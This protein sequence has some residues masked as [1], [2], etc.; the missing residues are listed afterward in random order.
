MLNGGDIPDLIE[1]IDVNSIH[2]YAPAP[3][4]FLC[5]GNIDATATELTSLR[6]AFLRFAYDE[7]YQKHNI[8]LAEE[9][10]GFFPNGQYD[11]I[12]TLESDLALISDLIILFSESM[13]SAAELGAFSMVHSIALNL[14]VIIDDKNYDQ[15]S[16]IALGPIKRLEITYGDSAVCVM[17]RDDVNIKDIKDVKNL[18]MDT[19]KQIV[20]SAI[21]ERLTN[22]NSHSTFDR[23]NEGHV[24]KLIVGMIQHY[25]ALTITEISIY[26]SCLGIDLP[27][28]RISDYLL[29]AQFAKWIL[30]DKRG[31]KTFYS[32][33]SGRNAI[34]YKIIQN[35]KYKN[36]DRWKS[37]IREYW[38]KCDPERFSSINYAVGY[39]IK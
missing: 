11:N 9:L 12:L 5:G 15:S 35:G 22:I 27:E 38:K 28:K 13:G 4:L 23:N 36:R 16:F 33:L 7:P 25:G 24:I 29:C 14:L 30:K 31:I 2:V 1:D 32:A 21:K 34:S 10:N 20:N 18:Q 17:N 26:L 39:N 3:V 19:F 37:D 6:S 8:L